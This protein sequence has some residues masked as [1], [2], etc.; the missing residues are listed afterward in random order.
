[1]WKGHITM[2]TLQGTIK[3]KTERLF[4]RRRTIDDAPQEFKN[5]QSD[6]EVTKHLTWQAYKN[7]KDAENYLKTQVL[8]NYE[9]KNFCNWAISYNEEVIGAIDARIDED[10]LSAM[11]GYCLGKAWWGQGIM[12]EALNAVINYLFSCGIVRVWAYHHVENPNSGRVMEKCGMEYEG[13]LRKYAKDN[14]GRLRDVKVYSII[15]EN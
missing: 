4:L 2:L 11:I 10:K 5:Y 6:D 15:N 1:M 3:I 13:T 7:P 9:N 14:Q 8:A 12:P